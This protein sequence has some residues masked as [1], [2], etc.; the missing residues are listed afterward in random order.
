[1]K[2]IRKYVWHIICAITL[3]LLFVRYSV[4][5]HQDGVNDGK[6]EY[7]A[8]LGQMEMERDILSD[9]I[10]NIYDNSDSKNQQQQKDILNYYLGIFNC[11]FDSLGNWS[12]CY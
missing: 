1:M 3:I 6:R 2:K 4:D 9:A 7:A 8:Q 11:N 12:Y 10:R 5:L